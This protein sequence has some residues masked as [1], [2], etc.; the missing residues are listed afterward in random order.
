MWKHS[1]AAAIIS[2]TVSIPFSYAQ[3]TQTGAVTG[4]GQ[5]VQATAKDMFNFIH[6]LMPMKQ[7]KK[8]KDVI[9]PDAK[10]KA[11]LNE[12]ALTLKRQAELRAECREAIR[13]ANRDELM[14]RARQCYRS[15]LLLDVGLQRKRIQYLAAHPQITPATLA[16]A[17]GAMTKLI[18]AEMSII[19][20]IDTGIFTNMEQLLETKRNLAATYKT[21]AW[22]T[23]TM[24]RADHEFTWLVFM[25]NK[26]E[27]RSDF[28]DDSS[29]LRL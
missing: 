14:V 13:R 1:F 10:E 17:S 12:S 11:W 26:L 21:P 15:D 24:F 16:T 9:V 2:L 27:E 3:E 4:S 18:D 7:P 20:A 29:R 22:L 5:V 19:D 6:A 28:G 23:L 25:V 8:L